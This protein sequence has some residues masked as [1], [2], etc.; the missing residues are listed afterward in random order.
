MEIY[1]KLLLYKHHRCFLKMPY[2]RIFRYI[3]EANYK[4]KAI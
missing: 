1:Y 4:C 3:T 2:C